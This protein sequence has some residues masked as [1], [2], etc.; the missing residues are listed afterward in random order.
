MA[1]KKYQFNKE[2]LSYTQVRR[3]W[4]WYV[5]VAFRYFL[6]GLALALLVYV[7]FS[8]FT[9][10]PSERRL[11]WERAQLDSAVVELNARYDQVLAVLS[12]IEGR[13][14]SIYRTI[15][16][17][18]PSES[19]A[20]AAEQAVSSLYQQLE[21]EGAEVLLR[22]TEG[23]LAKLDTLSET[24]SRRFDTVVALV[25][26]KGAAVRQIPSVQPVDNGKLTGMV[27]SFGRRVHPFYKVLRMHTGVDY[28]LP[29]GSPVYATADG[30]VRTIKRSE[31]GYGNMIEVEHG[32]L[33]STSYAH[34]E[35]IN[36]WQGQSVRRGDVIGEVGNTGLSMA[37]HLHYEVLYRG[38]AVDPVNYF[39]G[40][41][42]PLELER[43]ERNAAQRGQT[44]D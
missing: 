35:K 3:G 16:E 8:L 4:R 26:Q 27:A 12:D 25:K 6:A 40:E 41:L 39:F 1:A 38:E 15:F 33:Y 18:E 32:A 5:G 14:K 22:R 24:Q 29:V 20:E 17:S 19:D 34:L 31:R 9:Y 2:S 13:D 7:V 21:E 36:V 43:M 30:T 10:T 11:A 44:L 23:L 42:G 37:P 28:A